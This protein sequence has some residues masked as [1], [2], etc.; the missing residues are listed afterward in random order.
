MIYSA[1]SNAQF[2]LFFVRIVANMHKQGALKNT[3]AQKV[4]L[5]VQSDSL[6]K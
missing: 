6:N 3:F 4:P 2:S 1:G 5:F